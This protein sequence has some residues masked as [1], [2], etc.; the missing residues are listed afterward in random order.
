MRGPAGP[1]TAAVAVGWTLSLA[2]PCPTAAIPPHSG[3]CWTGWAATAPFW[4]ALADLCLGGWQLLCG[5]LT[6]VGPLANLGWC[7]GWHFVPTRAVHALSL[8]AGSVQPC[9]ALHPAWLHPPA[10]HGPVGHTVSATASKNPS[11]RADRV[12]C[13]STGGR[14][15][16]GQLCSR[17]MVACSSCPAK[18]SGPLRAAPRLKRPHH[19]RM[20]PLIPPAWASA[21]GL[22]PASLHPLHVLLGLFPLAWL[23]VGS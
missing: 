15:G 8:L 12:P 7:K 22:H 9:I 21:P 1:L 5:C 23:W 14:E 17:Q 3:R 19:W 16:G 11:L 10:F 2:L 6:P 18:L 13:P 20:L 4:V